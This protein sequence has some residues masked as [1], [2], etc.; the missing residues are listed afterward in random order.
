MS[1]KTARTSHDPLGAVGIGTKQAEAQTDQELEREFNA[2]SEEGAPATTLPTVPIGG[3]GWQIPTGTAPLRI[4]FVCTGNTCRSP[5]AEGMCTAVAHELGVA[6]QATSAGIDATG[7]SIPSLHA[8]AVMREMGIEISNHRS[9]QLKA[10]MAQAVDLVLAMTPTHAEDAR[11]I[12]GT[13]IPIW[14]LGEYAGVCE[15]VDDPIGG[16]VECYRRTA[17]QIHR[18]LREA[19]SRRREVSEPC[20]LSSEKVPAGLPGKLYRVAR[21]GRS[22]GPDARVRDDV[23]REWI[24]GVAHRLTSD[25]ALLAGGTIDYVCLLGRKDSG[26]REI[27]DFYNARGPQDGD[28]LITTSSP[29]WERYLNDLAGGQVRFVLHHVPT[30]DGVDL[31]PLQLREIRQLLSSLLTQGKTVL[32]GCSSAMGRTGE[33]LRGFA[34][35]S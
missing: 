28:D 32:V 15:A 22:L 5:M 18:L 4:L 20:R 6:V 17:E 35:L 19:L 2:G 31:Q 21:P 23:V 8:V 1:N 14:T 25:G 26:R 33:V 30:V 13:A 3:R 9:R 7:D 29:T 24:E 27:A 12:L 34:P 10:E 16:T 11:A